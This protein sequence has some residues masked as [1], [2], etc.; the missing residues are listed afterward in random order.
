MN[1]ITS[2]WLDSELCPACGTG[3]LITDDGTAAITQD[4]PACSWTATFDLAG[5]AGG[6]R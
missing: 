3:V 6:R 4:C 2:T 1:G 5:Q